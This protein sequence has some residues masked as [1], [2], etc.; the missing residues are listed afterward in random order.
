MAELAYAHDSGSCPGNW[1]RV[2]VPST[3]RKRDYVK[4]HNLFFISRLFSPHNLMDFWIY[5][6][7]GFPVDVPVF[8]VPPIVLH[9]IQD[10]QTVPDASFSIIVS[11]EIPDTSA[12]ILSFLLPSYICLKR[13][14]V[15]SQIMI[16]PQKYACILHAGEDGICH[17]LGVAGAAPVC[18]SCFL[19]NKNSFLVKSVC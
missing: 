10:S 19:H 4:S 2:Q 6:R 12:S 3:A 13:R 11:N 5:N 7:I 15:L 14:T 16:L 18:N 1:V 8:P 17:G 9:P